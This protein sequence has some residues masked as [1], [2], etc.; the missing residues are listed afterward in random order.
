MFVCFTGEKSRLTWNLKKA[1]SS[2]VARTNRWKPQPALTENFW[3]TF[4]YYL[5]ENRPH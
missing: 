5:L 4:E 2:S 3:E 1:R